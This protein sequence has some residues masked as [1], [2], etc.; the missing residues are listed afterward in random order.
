MEPFVAI[1]IRTT[2]TRKASSQ[3]LSMFRVMVMI[4]DFP[5]TRPITGSMME[6]LIVLLVTSMSG[7][8]TPMMK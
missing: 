2:L 5:W 6:H 4:I 8:T 3:T 1:P 7:K